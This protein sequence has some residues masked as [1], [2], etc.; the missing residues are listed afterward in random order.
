MQKPYLLAARTALPRCCRAG[1]FAS[2]LTLFLALPGLVLA[3][4]PTITGVSPASNARSAPRTSPVQVTFSQALTTGSSAAL[5]VHSLQRRGLRTA[6]TAAVVSGS[7]L[8]FTPSAPLPFMPGETVYST[9]TTTAASSAG[10]LAKANVSQFTAGVG[11]TGT[12]AFRGGSDVRAGQTLMGMAMGDVDADGDLDMMLIDNYT[13]A[14]MVRLNDGTG[15]F[16]TS[17]TITIGSVQLNNVIL[18]D[19]DGDGDLDMLMMQQYYGIAGRVYFNNGSGTFSTGAYVTGGLDARNVA[20]GD[21][22]GDGDLDVLVVDAYD[23]RVYTRFNDGTG[24]Y[25]NAPGDYRGGTFVG[26]GTTPTSVAVGDF[27]ADGDLDLVT[28]NSYNNTV[29]VRFNNGSGTFSGGT[30]VALANGGAISSGVVNVAVGD[31]DGDGDLDVLAASG[32][33]GNNVSVL[34]NNGSGTFSPSQYVAVGNGPMSVTLGDI[35]ADGD[36]DL[37]TANTNGS[38]ASVRLNNGTGTFGGGSDVGTGIGASTLAVVDLDGDGDLDLATSNTANPSTVSVRLNQPQAPAITSFA[39]TSG[40]VGTTLGLTGTNLM[41]A[42]AITFTGTSGNVVTTGYTVAST[43]SITGIVVPSGAQTGTLTVTAAG[44]TSAASSQTFTVVPAPVITSF[45]PTSGPV[46]TGVAIT[47]TNLLGTTAVFVNGTAATITGTTTATNLRFTVAAGSTSGALTLASPAGTAASAPNPVLRLQATGGSGG[48][49]TIY[50][51]QVEILQNGAVVTGAVSNPSFET[52]APAG[53]LNYSPT[54]VTPWTFVSNGGSAALST[55][56]SAFSPPAPPDGTAHLVVLQGGTPYIEQALTLAAGT[57]QVRMQLAQRQCC[58]SP[59]DQGLNV[60]INGVAVGATLS[61]SSAGFVSVVSTPFSVSAAGVFTLIPPPT[62]TSISPTPGVRGEAVTVTGT[63]LAGITGVSVNGVAA[64]AASF[65]GNTA[66]SLTFQ[67]PATAG[68]SGTTSVTT[69]GGT[70][71][72]ATFTTVAATPPGNALAFDGVDDFVSFSSTPAVNNLGPGSFTLEAWVYYDGGTGA[73]SIIRKDGD[74]NFYLNG[75]KLHA[76][77][78]PGGTSNAAF[79]RFDGTTTTLPANRWAHVAAVWN[80][81]TMQ[82]FVNGVSEPSTLYTSA[83]SASGNLTL[84]KSPTYGNLLNGRLDEVRI[85]TAALT[86]ANIQADLLST[87]AAVPA[88]LKFYLNFDQGTAGGTNTGQTTLYDQTASA[89]A[90]TLAN[91][92]LTGP[93]SNYVESYALV[94]PTATAA[95]SQSTSGFTANW[96]AP[97]VGTVDNGYRLDVSTAANLST[98]IAGSPFTASSGTSQAVTGLTTGT[99]Y[100][101]RVRADKTSV[102]GQGAYSNTVTVCPLPVAVARNAGVTLD[103]NGNATITAS[104]VN[105][106]STANCGPAAAGALSVSPSAFSCTDVVPATVA[107]ALTFN[108]TNQY[109][110]LPATTPVPVGNTAYTIEAWIKP[111]AMGTY[112]IIGWGNY[113]TDNQVNALRLYNSGLINYWWNRDIVVATPSLVGAW[114]HV[115]ATYDGTTRTLYLDGVAIGSDTPAPHA[116]PDASNLRI[117]STCPTFCGGEYFPGSI[118]EV[119]VWNVARTAAQLNTAKGV[120]LP[121]GTAGLVAYYR[122]NE[123]S[124]L[125]TADATGNAAN[126]GTLTNGPTWTTDAPAVTNGLPVTLTVTD[127][128]GN[129]AT[130][131]ALVTVSVP[132]TPTT[133]WNGSLS[134]GPL[135]CQNW[136]YGQVPD[137]AT[138][139]VVP[140]GQPRYPN[141][142]TGTLATKDLTINTGGSFTASG[143]ATLQVSGNLTNSG[144]A[145]FSGPVQFVGS[146]ATQTLSNGTGFTTVLVNKPTGT[147]QLAQTLTINS[148]LTLTSGTLTTTSSYQVNLGGSATLTES[149]ASYVVG[150]VVVSRTLTPGS[151]EPFAGLGLTLTPAAGSI[152]PGATLV[153]RTTGTAIAGA[154]TSQSILRNFDIR[155][156]TNAGLNVTMDFAYFDHERNGIPTANLALF[157]SVSGGTPWIPQRG[158]TAG[159]NVVTKTS[160]ADFSVWTLGNSANPLPVELT[161]FTATALTHAVRLQWRTASEKNTARFEVERSA[162]GTAF[163][164]L[165]TVAAAGTS[166]APRDYALTD[167]QLPAGNA[168]LY[169]RLKQ[170]DED[171][172]FSYSPVRSVR[173]SEAATGLVL[174]PNPATAR[175]LLSGTQPGTLVQVLDAVGRVVMS[176]TADATGTAALALPAGIATGVYVVRT[177]NKAL[178]LTVE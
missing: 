5:K 83:I 53:N 158:T 3:Q 10:A 26:V 96:T 95:T 19:V 138:N 48:D 84:G 13:A 145:T 6:A 123:G 152:A 113:G 164:R 176:A 172:S 146:A 111:T 121:G 87:A 94:V 105:N 77:V 34:I 144:T 128:G 162:D 43:T 131:P 47:G 24:A 18:G 126:L 106:G 101:Y 45:T 54:T 141:L 136:S 174:Y 108:G 36:L 76:E 178:R 89:Y 154:G 51:D 28:A 39:P 139:V 151:G 92:A 177:G 58:S 143:G 114:H 71:S 125:T 165:G 40:P 64:P 122:L 169:Y 173:P 61:T 91:F 68:A 148:G 20:F 79:Q 163:G 149:D 50:L 104:A 117:A 72:T 132:A 119:R 75:N 147:V 35:D 81:S 98:A 25:S 57:Y 134:T 46:G 88:S 103:V 142:T 30:N 135:A 159:P 102:T 120:G 99:T 160:I 4:G 171:G 100:Y 42:T 14:V 90:G 157:K 115:A 29:S 60:L 9:T 27:D 112:G 62:I 78:W 133:T 97:A 23:Q 16:T 49:K 110:A 69:A 137:A 80:G 129:T 168:T 59:S 85:Y 153:T 130:A 73:E 109:V 66:T 74:Y 156:A 21:V 55:T 67:V 12:G 8:T 175:T 82:L 170:V 107:S 56:A 166:T 167:A 70:A 124:G 31:V 44:G 150:K 7:T 161:D 2:L 15:N 155:P 17:Q 33:G 65:V 140:T 52:G 1:A 41:G 116:V 22:D 118:D 11:G 63:N 32:S 86:A 37:L 127:A 93:T 38:S